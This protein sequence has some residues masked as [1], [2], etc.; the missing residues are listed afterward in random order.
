MISSK[1]AAYVANGSE[2]DQPF[3]DNELLNRKDDFPLEDPLPWRVLDTE[4]VFEPMENK[5]DP[6]RFT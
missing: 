6:D 3:E 1:K 5:G 2:L 4:A